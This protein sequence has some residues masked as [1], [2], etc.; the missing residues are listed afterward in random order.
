[1][2]E[3][4]FTERILEHERGIIAA[5][6]VLMSALAWVYVLNGA[7]TGM[8]TLAMSTWRFPPPLPQAPAYS[9]WSLGHAAVMLLM[10]WVMMI[11]MMLPGAAPTILLYERIHRHNHSRGRLPPFPRAAAY[12][13][14]GYLLCW[15][16]FSVLATFL[17]LLLEQGGL[18]DT[19]TMWSTSRWLTAALLV[20]AGTYQLSPV[21]N[22]CL[23]H[24]RSPASWLSRNWRNGSWGALIMGLAHGAYCTGCCS[25]L[26]LLLFAGGIMN[27][28]WIAILSIFILAEKLAPFGMHLAKAT[29]LI[30]I[31]LGAWVAVGP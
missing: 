7:G 4:A 13:T 10:W 1:M 27:L 8:S 30:L 3:R 31:G 18:L 21:K 2:R 25:V 16:G 19:M 28:V 14:T 17:Q 12:F 9:D 5:A 6:L 22:L 11:A 29:A 24:C 26:M 15:M 23:T 20:A